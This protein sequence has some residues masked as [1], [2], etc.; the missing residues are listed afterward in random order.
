MVAWLLAWFEE[1]NHDVVLLGTI[2]SSDTCYCSTLLP[3]SCEMRIYFIT[4]MLCPRTL[5]QV[6]IN[7]NLRL[8][9]K[10]IINI[11]IIVP[12]NLVTS[13]KSNWY[14]CASQLKNT[15]DFVSYENYSLL[16]SGYTIFFPIIKTLSHFNYKKYI[17]MI[18]I[19]DNIYQTKDPGERN[20]AGNFHESWSSANH[21]K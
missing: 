11:Y 14:I 19:K 8:W 13:V 17:Y 18:Y 20:I 9:D 5:D 16:T 12:D 4:V 1:I 7:W 3:V 21:L 15:L 6:T 2:F 10:W